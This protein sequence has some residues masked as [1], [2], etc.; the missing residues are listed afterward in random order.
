MTKGSGRA[1][2]PE[3]SLGAALR[4][5][6]S[7]LAST[8]GSEA[9]LDSRILL[10]AASGMDRL[11]LL[12]ASDRPMGQPVADRFSAFIRRRFDGEPVWRVLGTREFWGLPFAV[13]PAVLDPRPDTESVVSAALKML[14]SRRNEPLRILDL[15][16]GSGAILCALCSELPL[17]QGWGVDRSLGACRIA[18]ANVAALG[19]STR[20]LIVN[21]DWAQALKPGSLDLVVSNP[22]YIE[23]DVIPTLAREVRE[24]DP[25]TALDGGPDGLDCY[26]SIASD[27]PR[28]LKP[29][30]VAVLEI[31]STQAKAVTTLLDES[32]LSVRGVHRDLGGH[33]RAVV[34]TRKGAG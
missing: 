4:R 18:M 7:L 28:L 2:V 32:G 23:T 22:P 30:G 34:A 9:A 27:L 26:R 33:D 6:A 31:G 16:T 1:I 29:H 15:G 12:N 24:F 17:A 11:A 5:G 13:T 25:L 21:G 8:S 14:S 10:E 19:L 3:L 20:L